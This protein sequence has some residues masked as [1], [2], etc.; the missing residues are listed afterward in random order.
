LIR[1]AWFAVVF[2]SP[3]LGRIDQQPTLGLEVRPR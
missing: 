1:V 3:R 2:L